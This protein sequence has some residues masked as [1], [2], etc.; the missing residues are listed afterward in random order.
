MTTSHSQDLK[1]LK[2][3]YSALMSGVVFFL[4][5]AFFLNMQISPFA[6]GDPFFEQTLLGIS[7][8]MAFISIPS[9]LFIFK[10][11]TEGI[12]KLA[13]D[14]KLSIYRSAMIIRASTM[15]ASG[16]FFVICYVLTGSQISLIETLLVLALMFFFFPTN[17]RL[18]EEMKHD[19]RELE[20]I[21]EK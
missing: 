8:L 18:S 14:E 7:T 1:S 11:R 16:F 4:I 2:I 17:N 19:L 15:E 12:D 21:Q 20:K 5:I 13:F 10:K 3:V 9:G 6:G